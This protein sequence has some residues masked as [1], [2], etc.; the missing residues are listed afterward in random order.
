M[1]IDKGVLQNPSVSLLHRS[2]LIFFY[3]LYVFVRLF[4][5][6]LK[7]QM[8]PSCNLIILFLNVLLILFVGFCTKIVHKAFQSLRLFYVFSETV[9]K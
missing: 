1:E 7:M 6:R 4:V 2:F 5:F 9:V 8:L 3:L